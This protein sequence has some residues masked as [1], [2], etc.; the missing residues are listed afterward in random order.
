MRPALGLALCAGALAG[1]CSMLKGPRTKPIN[2]YLADPSDVAP[3]RRVMLLPFRA[4]DGVEAE[5]TRVRD[6]FGRELAKIQ[7]FEVV[8]L[9]KGTP[10][11]A[12]R[13]NVSP[14]SEATVSDIGADGIASPLPT[15]NR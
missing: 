1:G 10:R 15:R 9:P 4:D 5:R 8:P 6:A 12:A 2:W 14:A 7:R 3:V 11:G 13:L